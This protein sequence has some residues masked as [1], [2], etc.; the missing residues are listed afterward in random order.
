MRFRARL[1][2]YSIAIQCFQYEQKLTCTCTVRHGILSFLILCIVLQR[3]SHKDRIISLRLRFRRL[4]NRKEMNQ[5]QSCIPLRLRIP[6][7]D[8]AP[9]SYGSATLL[10]DIVISCNFN[11]LMIRFG[12]SRLNRSSIILLEPEPYHAAAPVPAPPICTVSDIKNIKKQR[13]FEKIILDLNH[14]IVLM[15]S[16][17]IF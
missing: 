3:R 13:H 12:W 9:C 1:L 16:N 8:L 11:M 2:S 14:L 7:N 15:P 6:E 10:S 4:Q 17:E 5:S